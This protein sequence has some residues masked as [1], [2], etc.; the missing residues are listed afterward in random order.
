M[1]L[2]NANMTEVES[3]VQK[4]AQKKCVYY[5]KPLVMPWLVNVVAE[6]EHETRFVGWG[7]KMSSSDR[8]RPVLAA[9][10]YV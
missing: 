1:S 3:Q 10:R 8:Y 5:I 6:G 7:E 4:P 2:I 9:L